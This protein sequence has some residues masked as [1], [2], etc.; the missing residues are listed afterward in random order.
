MMPKSR[1]KPTLAA[2]SQLTETAHTKLTLS[3]VT[4]FSLISSE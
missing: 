2:Q 3:C 4:E 1:E